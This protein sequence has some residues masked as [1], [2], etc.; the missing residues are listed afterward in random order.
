[1]TLFANYGKYTCNWACS[2]RFVEPATDQLPWISNQI[3][4]ITI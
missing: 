3:P 4:V 2:A 1:M